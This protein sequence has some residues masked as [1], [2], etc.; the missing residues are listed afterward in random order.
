[1]TPHEDAVIVDP[2]AWHGAA[3]APW[4][5]AGT[6]LRLDGVLLAAAAAPAERLA[7]LIDH[8][9]RVVANGS[10]ARQ[11]M[12]GF[13][14]ILSDA[15]EEVPAFAAVAPHPTGL[16]VIVS[17]AVTVSVNGEIL[18]GRRS[19]AWVDRV[20]PWPVRGLECRVD[21]GAEAP[22][23]PYDLAR[24]V[25]PAGGFSLGAP[26]SATAPPEE[27]APDL[28]VVNE[29]GQDREDIPTHVSIRLGELD[30]GA[31]LEPRDKLPHHHEDDGRD[32]PGQTHPGQGHREHGHAE[33]GDRAERVRGVYCKNEHFNDP[34][35]LFC[36]VC[37]I[38]MV[39]QTPVL[40]EGL[41]PPLGVVVVD[42]GAV[43]QVDGH[44]LV[45]REPE[46][47]ERAHDGGYRCI[48]VADVASQISRVHAR[49]ELRGW[50]VVLID[51]SSTNG[52]FLMEKGQTE[53]KRIATE[54]DVLLPPGSRFRVGN[55][56]LAFTTHHGT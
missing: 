7:Q 56:T 35:M 41:R 29:V 14:L 15:G 34:R 13:A 16:A 48:P 19:L 30:D 4:S 12:R 43:F 10:D 47:D 23:G 9:E 18:D 32:R 40:V 45:G 6:L 53:W 26:R 1:M 44:Y 25:V 39:Q 50:D 51:D 20:F 21:D 36:A 52:T 22:D 28:Q 27:T 33:R 11:L 54:T 3:V 42:D 46:S 8:V 17:G 37:G 49:L 24:G 5:G 38:N 31:D 2:V 55:R